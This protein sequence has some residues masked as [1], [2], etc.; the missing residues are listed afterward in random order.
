MAI[1][2]NHQTNTVNGVSGLVLTTSNGANITLT[3]A[4][5]AINVT[6]SLINNVVDPVQAQ[7]AATKHY[8]DNQISALVNGADTLLDTLKE[9]AD[10]LA[11]DPQF[12]ANIATSLVN[13]R[14]DLAT[15][16]E[17]RQQGDADTL[18]AANTY[19]DTKVNVADNNALVY[20]I[21]FGG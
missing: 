19:T 17:N 1:N 11:N 15:E 6:T 18:N 2:I 12:A 5:G 21:A 3:S 16:I 14:K 8:V 7:D 9:L 20:A 4:S 13:L 10:A